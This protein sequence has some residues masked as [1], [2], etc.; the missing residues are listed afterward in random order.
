MELAAVRM[1]DHG[2]LD[3]VCPPLEDH[4]ACDSLESLELRETVADTCRVRRA[5][6]PHDVREEAERV[7]MDV[8]N[9]LPI[10]G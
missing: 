2:A 7:V 8:L 10:P 1:H 6:L 3:G 5:F 4:R 9:R